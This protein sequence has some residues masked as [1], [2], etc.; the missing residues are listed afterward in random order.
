M[1]LLSNA[2]KFY[3]AFIRPLRSQVRRVAFGMYPRVITPTIS[4]LAA[5]WDLSFHLFHVC[6]LSGTKSLEV[7]SLMR[8][9]LKRLA[10]S[11]SCWMNNVVS[12][13]L[14]MSITNKI[15]GHGNKQPRPSVLL[16]KYAAFFTNQPDKTVLQMYTI[17]NLGESTLPGIK[18]QHLWG[19]PKYLKYNI[20]PFLITIK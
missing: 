19:S 20:F 9:F 17:L 2:M 11:L 15:F 16:V 8:D 3:E 10:R 14:Y 4:E 6:S 18:F 12:L 5:F 7:C 13:L 1:F